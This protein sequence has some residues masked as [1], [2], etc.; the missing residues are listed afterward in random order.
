MIDTLELTRL[1]Q[2]LVQELLE[3]AP[4]TL[5]KFQVVATESGNSMQIQLTPTFEL[6]EDAVGTLREIFVLCHKSGQNI[7]GI[8]ADVV[9]QPNQSWKMNMEYDY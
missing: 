8:R 1:Q 9:E 3:E 2:Q 5:K 4:D 6:N 7:T